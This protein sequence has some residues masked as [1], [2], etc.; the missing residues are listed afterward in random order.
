METIAPVQETAIYTRDAIEAMLEA[1]DHQLNRSPH[2]NITL[3]TTDSDISVYIAS[4][5]VQADV[6]QIRIETPYYQV[7]FTTNFIRNE[8]GTQPLTV[9]VNRNITRNTAFVPIG[10]V[11]SNNLDFLR[12]LAI[13]DPGVAN[14]SYEVNFNRG[15]QAVQVSHP[16]G[17]SVLPNGDTPTCYQVLQSEDGEIVAARYNPSTN[18]LDARIR[19]EGTFTVVENRVDFA[20]IQESSAEMQRAIRVLASQGL[21]AGVGQGQFNPSDPITR[22]QFASLI[23]RMLGVYNANSNGQFSDVRRD[24]WF[25]G[26]AGSARRHGL[27]SG[28][29][30]NIFSPHMVMP[31]E[32]LVA[33]AAR[34]LRNEMGYRNP[35]TPENYLRFVDRAHLADWST[36]DIALASRENLIVRRADRHFL[37]RE[38][39]TR[40]D[41][42]MVLY[43]LYIR[44][45]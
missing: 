19:E 17:V 34:V 2:A 26:A 40:G 23:T 27:M 42:A 22:A 12:Y 11:A 44:L 18:M 20:D 6:E 29:A 37:P 24:D 13:P 4:D 9:S 39:M 21:I 38:N 32:Q 30:E 15:D 16:I 33:I 10:V 3:V 43:R 7:A 36:N 8:A 45:W 28:T 25:F 5:S 14:R 35:A 31:R 1:H 41:A